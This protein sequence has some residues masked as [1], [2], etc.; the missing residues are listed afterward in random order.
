M[1]ISL[2][3]DMLR[4]AY[5]FLN[6]TS[7]FNKWNLPDGEEIEFRVVRSRDKYAYHDLDGGKQTIAFSSLTVGHTATLIRVMAH[8][9]VHVHERRQSPSATGHSRAFVRWSAQ[10]CKCHG[11]DPKEF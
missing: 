4:A 6:E 10:V 2:S 8:E 5:D 3:P 9:M 7:P 1:T 11:F